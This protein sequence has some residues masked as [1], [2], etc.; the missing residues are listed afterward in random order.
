MS[1]TPGRAP[2]L[3]CLCLEGARPSGL[4]AFCRP[5]ADVILKCD[6]CSHWLPASHPAGSTPVLQCLCPLLS[7]GHLR[8]S[9]C[10]GV[11]CP[12]RCSGAVCCI[13][14]VGDRAS[15][16]GLALCWSMEAAAAGGGQCP[17]CFL[18]R[19]SWSWGRAGHRLRRLETPAQLPHAAP[20]GPPFPGGRHPW[21]GAG[22]GPA[23]TLTEPLSSAVGRG[24][25]GSGH[26]CSSCVRGRGHLVVRA[27]NSSRQCRWGLRAQG[28][29][30]DACEGEPRVPTCH[31][32]SAPWPAPRAP[33]SL[34]AA[35][36]CLQ[37]CHS[38]AHPA[39]L[40]RRAPP[41]AHARACGQA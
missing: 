33:E 1:I 4:G 2:R 18:C 12:P 27:V 5:R 20:C 30:E 24:P 19:G 26:P 40:G 37:G 32:P 35:P 11:G 25:S 39:P 38:P 36:G 13:L 34:G 22:A 9:P 14:A 10:R 17:C 31:Q 41:W 7:P 23:R 8:L 28:G 16:W 3:P 6:S 21:L 29:A 15:V